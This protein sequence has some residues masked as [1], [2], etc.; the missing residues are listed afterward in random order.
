MVMG[1]DVGHRSAASS[2]ISSPASASVLLRK[3]IYVTAT[4]VGAAL[5]VVLHGVGLTFWPAA[6]LGAGAAFAVRAGALQ[7][8]STL[9]SYRSCG[10]A[11]FSAAA[12]IAQAA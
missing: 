1:V 7:A 8:G 12:D 11:G 5:F 9:P 10:P 4:L 2:A 3:E 6:L